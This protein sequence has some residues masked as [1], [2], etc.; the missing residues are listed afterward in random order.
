MPKWEAKKK[1]N[2]S[3]VTTFVSTINPGGTLEHRPAFF[4]NQFNYLNLNK[5]ILYLNKYK[6][7]LFY[8]KEKIL[9]GVSFEL[10]HK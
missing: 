7:D 5:L 9:Y 6:P 1:S 4:F 10:Q 8:L 3:G 2:I